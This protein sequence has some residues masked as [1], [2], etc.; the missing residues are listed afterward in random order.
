MEKMTT[1]S[2]KQQ[3]N[4]QDKHSNMKELM[5]EKIRVIECLH[6]KIEKKN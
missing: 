6:K 3:S 4:N 5:K 1:S 2:H